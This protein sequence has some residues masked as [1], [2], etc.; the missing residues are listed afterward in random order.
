MTAEF[1]IL[2]VGEVSEDLLSLCHAK[3]LCNSIKKQLK[4]DNFY[5]VDS[6]F[7]RSFSSS[8]KI[9][10]VWKHKLIA[11]WRQ[12]W[13]LSPVT[14]WSSGTK[15]ILSVCLSACVC[16]CFE[17]HNLKN[18]WLTD[19]HFSVCQRLSSPSTIGLSRQHPKW[20]P[21]YVYVAWTPKLFEETTL[22]SFWN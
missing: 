8:W 7:S 2:N 6:K 3:I 22:C 4:W 12:F 19:F 9:R 5:K 16:T 13:F 21:P 11:A 17:H 20:L 14:E 18:K 15:N 10:C 1:H